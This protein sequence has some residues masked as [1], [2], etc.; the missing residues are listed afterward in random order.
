MGP[1]IVACVLALAGPGDPADGVPPVPAAQA[2]GFGVTGEVGVW[3]PR[4]TGTASVG[5]GGTTF[6]L[7]HDLAVGDS[8]TGI[9]GEFAIA[10]GRWRFGGIGFA[11]SESASATAGK[12]GTFGTVALSVGDRISGSYSA[13]M[14]GAEVQY[15][16]WNPTGTSPWPWG[17]QGTGTE[18]AGRLRGSNGRP[19]LDVAF[20]LLGGGLAMHYEQDLT[21]LTTGQSSGF[22]RTAAAPYLGAGLDVRI[23]FDGRVPLVQDLRIYANSGAGVTVPGGELVWMVRVGIS[24]MVDEN[25]GVELGYRL[26]DFD[27]VD[28]PSE[29]DAGL[30][31][32]FGGVSIRF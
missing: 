31:G 4:L 21:D 2:D 28:G 15:E 13:W 23:G 3:V 10:F 19:L 16:L 8:T 17:E 22:D 32:L 26:F 6:E 25:I 1:V 9:A 27:L 18:E 14:A 30:R 5:A 12:A 29:V 11:T 20:L 7:N 24:L